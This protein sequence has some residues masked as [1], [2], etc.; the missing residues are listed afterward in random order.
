MDGEW[1]D[2]QE[3]CERIY[4][5]WFSSSSYEH[6][7]APKILSSTDYKSEIRVPVVQSKT[8]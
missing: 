5:E 3:V 4:T 7:G 1:E 6:A 2:V 8:D